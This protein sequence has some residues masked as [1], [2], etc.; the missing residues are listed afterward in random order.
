MSTDGSYI[1]IIYCKTDFDL[2]STLVACY[3]GLVAGWPARAVT[4]ST[5]RR[6][7]S[8]LTNCITGPEAGPGTRKLGLTG[9]FD[10]EYIFY[11]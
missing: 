8:W 4:V 7:R 2:V 6:R 3:V 10:V 9:Y 11:T 5:D 1:N